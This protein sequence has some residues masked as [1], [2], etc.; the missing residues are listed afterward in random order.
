M[1]S[2]VK[3][4]RYAA[5]DL[6]SAIAS[7]AIEGLVVTHEAVREVLAAHNG[8]VTHDEYLRQLFETY[9]PAHS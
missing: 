9:A 5:D 3:R 6:G 2:P 1:E 4:R 7:L 8:E